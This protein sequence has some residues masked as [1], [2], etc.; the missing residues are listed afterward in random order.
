MSVLAITLAVILIIL[1]LWFI[2]KSYYNSQKLKQH[3]HHQ[4]SHHPVA[5]QPISISETVLP[6]HGSCPG[7][8]VA[9]SIDVGPIAGADMAYYTNSSS[10]M[11]HMHSYN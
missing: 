5:V 1:F 10:M 7:S 8:I 9:E 4:C 11:P 6:G 3:H 2:A